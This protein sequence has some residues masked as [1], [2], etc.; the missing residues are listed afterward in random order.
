MWLVAVKFVVEDVIP[1][2]KCMVLVIQRIADI[3][4]NFDQPSAGVATENVLWDVLASS[5]P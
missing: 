1:G 5:G 3:S 2:N 4:D